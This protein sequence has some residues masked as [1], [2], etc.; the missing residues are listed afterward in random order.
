MYAPR[1][2]IID[3]DNIILDLFR[4]DGCGKKTAKIKGTK[5]VSEKNVNGTNGL[6][7]YHFTM[8]RCPL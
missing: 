6:T 1:I 3:D 7:R 5:N 4:D 8:R 2:I